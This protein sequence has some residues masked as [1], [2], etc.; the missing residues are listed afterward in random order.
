MKKFAPAATRALACHWTCNKERG[1]LLAHL[2]SSPLAVRHLK[3]VTILRRYKKSQEQT[4]EMP[5]DIYDMYM[6]YY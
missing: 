6:V 3:A 4:F 5:A 2:S 1:V